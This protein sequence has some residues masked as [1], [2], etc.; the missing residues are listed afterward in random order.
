MAV[1]RITFPLDWNVPTNGC[2]SPVEVNVPEAVLAA[3]DGSRASGVD[4]SADV[5][6][7]R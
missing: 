2:S 7:E 5:F 3:G 1:P 4:I 6:L